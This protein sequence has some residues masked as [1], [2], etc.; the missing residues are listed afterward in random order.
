LWA[1]RAIVA[2]EKFGVTTGPMF[3]VAGLK[4][5]AKTKRSKMGDLDP[6]FHEVLKRVQDRWPH[7]ISES[8]KVEDDYSI[9]RSLRRGSTSRAQNQGIAASVVEANQ[10][11]RKHERSQGVL[12][13]MGMM[14][15]CSDA[16]ASVKTLPQYSE[17]L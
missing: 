12:P 8:V 13:S 6:A 17:G 5:G 15:R 4:A 10:R 16:K 11:W 1:Y 14:K 9:R 3:R 2:Y 7:V